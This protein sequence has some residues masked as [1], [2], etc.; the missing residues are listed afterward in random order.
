MDFELDGKVETAHTPNT[1]SMK[2]LLDEGNFVWVSESDNPKRKLKYTTEIIEFQKRK[3]RR[4]IYCL[5]NTQRPNELVFEW[6]KNKKIPEIKNFSEIKR[7]AKYG[8]NSRIDILAEKK[9]GQKI[10]V[11]V[12]NATLKIEENVCAFPD[13]KTE[14]GRKHLE[15]LISEVEKGNQAFAF[16]MISR[17]DCDYFRV[18]KEIDEK[19]YETYQRAKKLG[20]KFLAYQIDFQ[21]QGNNFDLRLGKR[22]KILD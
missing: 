11:E 12:K 15:E 6:I 9:N 7:E 16:F 4:K 1:G 14:R 20:V 8:E 5:V 22:V 19:F 13:A 18:A 17:N 10:F 3:N 2:T 21:K